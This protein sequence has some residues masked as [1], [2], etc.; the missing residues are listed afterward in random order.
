MH[1]AQVPLDVEADNLGIVRGGEE[2]DGEPPM[3][4][5]R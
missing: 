5:T 4:D 3:D 2:V 1:K